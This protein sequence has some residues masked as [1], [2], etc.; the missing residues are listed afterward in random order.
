MILFAL[1]LMMSAPIDAVPAAP[2]VVKPVSVAAQEA[3]PEDDWD[4]VVCHEYARTGSRLDFT[5]VCMTKRDW[6]QNQT[7]HDRYLQKYVS[8]S[9]H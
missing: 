9:H 1:T 3:K 7:D 5:K 4:K 6:Y 8:L 2:A